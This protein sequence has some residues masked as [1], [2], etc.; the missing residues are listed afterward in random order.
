MG[1]QHCSV[2][3]EMGQVSLEWLA[4]LSFIA[5]SLLCCTAFELTRL[6]FF[7]AA[8]CNVLCLVSCPV[9]KQ[10]KRHSN[11]TRIGCVGHPSYVSH[12]EMAALGGPIIKQT[13]G[14]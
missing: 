8:V 13:M 5:G 14:W 11:R 1:I 9:H 6:H 4:L 12:E 10:T 3:S 2:S 7:A